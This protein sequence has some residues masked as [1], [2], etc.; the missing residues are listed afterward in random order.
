MI[1]SVAPAISH[2][3]KYTAFLKDLAKRHH[4]EAPTFRYPMVTNKAAG[5]SNLENDPHPFRQFNRELFLDDGIYDS[6]PASMRISVGDSRPND[7]KKPTKKSLAA[8]Q[9]R[10]DR[11]V[12]AIGK[13]Q[14]IGDPNVEHHRGHDVPLLTVLKRDG[15]TEYRDIVAA[16]RKLAATALAPAIQAMAN[17]YEGGMNI[18]MRSKSLTPEEDVEAAAKYAADNDNDWST[19]PKGEIKYKREVVKLKRTVVVDTGKRKA[20]AENDYDGEDGMQSD[21]LHVNFSESTLHE[22]ID[23][24]SRFSKT[25]AMLGPLLAPFEDAVLGGFTMTTIGTK[26]GFDIKPDL[27]GKAMCLRALAALRWFWHDLDTLEAMHADNDNMRYE[28]AMAA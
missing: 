8:E 25:R 18:Q 17:G 26:E 5:Y 14:A 23:A 20:V 1:T 13:R 7:Y 21:T 9:K 4:V 16:Y 24:K 22:Q 15:H 19:L 2:D 11:L 12:T 28:E 10:I 6:R 3:D 27:I